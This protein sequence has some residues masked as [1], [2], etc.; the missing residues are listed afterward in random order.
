M[1]SRKYTH[2]DKSK[3]WLIPN[4]KLHRTDGPAV[5]WAD[6]SKEWHLKGKLHR[7]DGPAIEGANGRKEWWLNGK[8]HRVD[9]PAI[10]YPNG[11]KEWY[12]N[13]EEMTEEKYNKVMRLCRRMVSKLKTALR[14]KYVSTLNETNTCDEVN[15]YTIIAGYMI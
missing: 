6:G 11:R 4:E 15:L 10:I 1:K 12:F 14:R 2:P 3:F 5:E 13:G 8:R 9:G 7:E